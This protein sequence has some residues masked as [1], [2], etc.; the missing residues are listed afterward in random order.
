MRNVIW[1]FFEGRLVFKGLS[2]EIFLNDLF[3]CFFGYEMWGG[4]NCVLFFQFGWVEFCV[5][6]RRICM[7][8]FF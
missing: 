6:G 2:L 3:V 8:C 1:Y 5:L 4:I 7:I